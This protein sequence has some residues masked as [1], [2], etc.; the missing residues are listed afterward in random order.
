MAAD[1]STRPRQYWDDHA[2]RFKHKS[3]ADAYELRPPYP[4]EAFEILRD[5]LGQA[6]GKVLDV[7]CGTGKIAR[8]LVDYADGVDAIDFSKDM[9]RV[10]KSLTNG[11]HPRLRWIHGRVEEVEWDSPY[12]IV[13]AGASI[14]WMEWKTVFPRFRKA[15]PDDGQIVIIDG[16]RP[17]QPPWREA[18]LVLIRKFSMNPHFQ[19][20]DLIQELEA[21]GHLHLLE[22]KLTGPVGF[23]QSIRDYVGSFHSRESLSVEHMGEANAAAFDTRL[24]DILFEYADER[25]ILS[26][27]LQARV[28]WGQPLD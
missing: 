14:H 5:L 9:I 13:T 10:G 17:I 19:D 11:D 27:D 22:D 6:P 1:I 23:S 21:R 20:I 16:D 15:M 2:S 4:E 28:A 18:E 3:L 24:S 26:F 8:R 7:G 12:A 25:G